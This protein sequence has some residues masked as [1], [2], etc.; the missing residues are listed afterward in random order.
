MENQFEMRLLRNA[1]SLSIHIC[2]CIYIPPMRHFFKYLPQKYLLL[3]QQHNIRTELIRCDRNAQLMYTIF[4]PVHGF[5][6][7]SLIKH[8]DLVANRLLDGIGT[9]YGQY[10]P[11]LR[12]FS[13]RLNR[14]PLHRGIARSG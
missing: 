14:H 3:I 2:V 9:G 6:E 4:I 12:F 5:T 13:V 11:R 7:V 10:L 1:L 8:F